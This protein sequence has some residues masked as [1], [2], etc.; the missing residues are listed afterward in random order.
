MMESMMYKVCE[1]QFFNDHRKTAISFCS[2]YGE[3]EHTFRY[4]YNDYVCVYTHTHTHII[5]V[6][7]SQP[8]FS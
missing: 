4:A 5:V 3:H 7:I 2:V 8:D 1:I 6:T